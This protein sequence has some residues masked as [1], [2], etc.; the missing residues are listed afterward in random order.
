MYQTA[1]EIISILDLKPLN[2]EG[3]YFKETYRSSET[4][5]RDCLPR[6]YG[7]SKAFSTAIYY[8]LTPGTFSS[9]HMLP[10]DELYH[11]YLGDPVEMLQ[12]REDGSGQIMIIGQDLSVGMALQTVVQRGTWQGSKLVDGGK[13]ALMG[14]TMSP[15]FDYEDFIPGDKRFLMET[16]PGFRTWIEKLI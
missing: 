12:L 11:F 10:T 16:Y 7:S 4:I 9:L 5:P 14:T 13:F 1:E 15:A 3:G 6:R 2:M 8:L